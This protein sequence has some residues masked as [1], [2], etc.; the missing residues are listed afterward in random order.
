VDGTRIAS[1]SV[2]WTKRYFILSAY[3]AK[4][5]LR[6]PK[7]HHCCSTV[8]NLGDYWESQYLAQIVHVRT[9]AVICQ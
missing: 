9:V 8:S 7:A 5:C 6:Y 1:T 4:L 2:K 3:V